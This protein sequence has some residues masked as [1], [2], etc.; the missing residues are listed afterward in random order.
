MLERMR[1]QLGHV[2]E[3]LQLIVVFVQIGVAS[4][5]FLLNFLVLTFERLV[6]RIE[7]S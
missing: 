3:H 5:Y 4:M 1:S 6:L 2:V 7:Q